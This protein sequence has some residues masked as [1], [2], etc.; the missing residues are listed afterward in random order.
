MDGRHG[1]CGHGA[2]AAGVPGL[3]ALKA[4]PSAT[5]GLSVHRG[6]GRP[7]DSRQEQTSHSPRNAFGWASVL[8]AA[9]TLELTGLGQSQ[10]GGRAD[11]TGEFAGATAEGRGGTAS[12][13]ATTDNWCA[14]PRCSGRGGTGTGRALSRT[15]GKW[16]IVVTVPTSPYALRIR[17][18]WVM[19]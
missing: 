2:A 4:P 7:E 12:V 16:G 3:H 9:S 5:S 8:E 18:A 17:N 11:P 10:P 19:W 14:I 1:A 15:P 6:T 13:T